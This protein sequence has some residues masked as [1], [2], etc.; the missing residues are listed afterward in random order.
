MQVRE[1]TRADVPQIVRIFHDTI[2][3]VNVRDYTAEQVSA[4]SPDV[5]DADAWADRKLASRTTF[6]ADDNGTIAGFGELENNGH[7]DCFYCHFN[8]QRCGIGSSILRQIED[9]ARCLVLARL[10][11]EASITA[12]PFFEAHGFAV[13]KRQTVIR[14]GVE[15]TNFLMEKRGLHA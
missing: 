4:W 11:V 6:V 12:R 3:T 9:R 8:Y 13:L 14:R 2:H 10:F 7:I 1:A 15:L 5:P